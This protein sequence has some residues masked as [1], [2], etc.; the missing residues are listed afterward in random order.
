MKTP[1][2]RHV[3]VFLRGWTGVTL[4]LLLS[5][6]I[7]TLGCQ[8]GGVGSLGQI[9]NYAQSAVKVGKAVAKTFQDITPEQEY[10]VGR[11]VGAILA[12]KYKPYQNQ[13]AT[14]YLNV[15]GQTLAQASDRPETFGGYHFAVL[16]SNEINAFAA[17]GGLI[18]VSR[19]MLQCCKSEDAV[20]AVLAHEI[21]HVAKQHGLQAIK[22][23][24]FTEAAG[25]IG[26][27]AA[28]T[29]AGDTLAQATQMFEDSLMDITSTLVNNGYSRAF[30]AEADAAAVVILKRVGYN[31][32][33]LVDMLKVMEQKLTPGGVDFAKTHP[34]PKDRINEIQQIAGAYAEVKA[35]KPRQT[36]FAS[37]LGNV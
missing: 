18:F 10:Y 27:E 8:G 35:P 25:I 12:G 3:I 16:D 24:R 36:R 14:N 11:A 26:V 4:L 29:M 34:A 23:S 9:A 19:G 21:G 22:K 15:L 1:F 7:F 31:P 5:V 13:R 20:A 17:P 2:S 6:S 28:K 33:G 37:A 30:E 32:N